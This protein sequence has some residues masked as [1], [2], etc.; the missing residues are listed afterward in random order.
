LSIIEILKEKQEQDHEVAKSG[1]YKLVGGI[2]E[3]S[4]APWDFKY[5]Q[6]MR[7]LIFTAN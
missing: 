5:V 7:H 3:D 6:F 2:A 4:D 1:V